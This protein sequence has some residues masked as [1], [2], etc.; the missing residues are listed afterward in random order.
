[1]DFSKVTH[2]YFI[3]VGGIGMSAI[4]RYFNLMGKVVAGY[5][6]TPTVLTDTLEQEGVAIH[7]IAGQDEIPSQFLSSEKA[8]VLVVVTPAVPDNH[9]ELEYFRANG[10]AIAKRSQVLGA[11]TRASKGIA[12]AGTH[13]KTSVTTCVSHLLSNSAVGCSAFLGGISKN[14][15]SNFLFNEKSDYVAI[16][17]DEYDR[18]FLTLS[19]EIA[20]ITAMD[21]DHLDIYGNYEAI[22]QAFADF[23]EKINTGGTLIHKIGLPIGD[24]AQSLAKNGVKTLTY[25]LGDSN[26]DFYAA[27]LS[28]ENGAYQADIYTPGGCIEKCVFNLP[29]KLNVENAIAAIAAAC[30]AGAGLHEIKDALAVFEGVQR[31][32]DYHWKS[33]RYV[34]I[35]DYAHHP[36]EIEA[37]VRSV[38]ELY[39]GKKLTGVFQPHLF[40][41]TRDF[42]GAFAQSLSLLDEVVL[43]DI[44]P[45]RELPIIGVTSDI[46][47]DAVTVGN[48]QLC[49]KEQ[50]PMELRQRDFEVLLTMG[51]GDIDTLIKPIVKVIRDKENFAKPL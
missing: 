9:P 51:A 1:M 43:L 6:R 34:Y 20:V 49:A 42:S 39:P 28:I 31:R 32:F 21:A 13:G 27:N 30:T 44:Y 12:I 29:G 40:T 3:G 7:Y 18:S 26:A 35:D 16:E 15:G 36:A 48:K 17:A 2:I 50:L 24:Y 47:L 14:Y 22:E 11:I 19:P 23:A 4:A 45:A 33:D 41:R 5:D 37:T 46:I 25:S 38:R 8:S 10:Y